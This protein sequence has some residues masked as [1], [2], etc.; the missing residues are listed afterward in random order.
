MAL[1]KKTMYSC[2]ERAYYFITYKSLFMYLKLSRCTKIKTFAYL[3]VISF[4]FLLSVLFANCK[5][6]NQESKQDPVVVTDEEPVPS[7]SS[8][9]N[10][11]D[12][13]DQPGWDEIAF[14]SNADDRANIE[15]EKEHIRSYLRGALAEYNTVKAF[16]PGSPNPNA[17]YK[18]EKFHFTLKSRTPLKYSVVAFL[19]PP[20]TR[21]GHGENGAG[22]HL[23]PPPPPPPPG[24]N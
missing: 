18:V 3:K 21:T 23:I 9:I 5:N 15:K 10:W 16:I 19:N 24:E 12:V 1:Q 7:D 22:Q 2:G 13:H 6:K 11:L 20:A 4:G 14:K 8:K 17:M